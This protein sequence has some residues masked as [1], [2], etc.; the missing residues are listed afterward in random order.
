[1]K[2]WIAASIPLLMGAF[3]FVALDRGTKSPAGPAHSVEPAGALKS[4]N[5]KADQAHEW[6]SLQEELKKKPGHAPILFRMAEIARAQGKPKEAADAL[7]QILAQEASNVEARL[8][9]GRVLF[10]AGDIQGAIRETDQILRA[11]PR[12]VDALYNLGAIYGNTGRED[13]ARKYWAQA[14]AAD[15]ASPSGR[16]AK[17][18]LGRLPPRP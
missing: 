12:H 1:M 5:A 14:V 10:E 11:N 17:E 18:A 7:G 2:K 4:A 6:R 16:Q 9:L 8:E 3:V 13:L 15:P